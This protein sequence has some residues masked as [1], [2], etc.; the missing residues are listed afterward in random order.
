MFAKGLVRLP[1][2][3][4]RDVTDELRS[5]YSK[6][7]KLNIDDPIKDSYIQVFPCEVRVTDNLF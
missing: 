6:D 3:E 5:D 7:R 1:R 4:K 2:E